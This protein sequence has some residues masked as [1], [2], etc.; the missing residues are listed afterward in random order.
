[1]LF[2][3]V[4]ALDQRLDHRWQATVLGTSPGSC[5]VD[6]GTRRG[7]FVGQRLDVWRSGIETYDEDLVRIG[8][9]VLVGA[10][11]IT[12]LV[13]RGRAQA[14]VLEGEVSYGDLARPCSTDPAVANT[15]R[16]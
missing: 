1:M 16:R 12:S 11:E 2:E 14:R 5:V 15:L 4:R 3:L 8:D 10:I 9:E 6:A 7:L 13:G